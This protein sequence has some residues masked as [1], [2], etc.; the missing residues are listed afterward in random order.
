[1]KLKIITIVCFQLGI[2][3]F[4]GIKIFKQETSV[5]GETTYT[6]IHKKDVIFNSDSKLQFFYEPIAKTTEEDTPPLSDLKVYY[7]I[8]S[9]HLH[10]R[11]DYPINKLPNSYRIMT[12]GDSFTFGLFANTAENY[13]EKLER[14][15]SETCSNNQKFE[16]INLGVSGYDIQYSVERFLLR[17]QKYEPDMI[18]FLLKEDD[19]MDIVEIT[20]PI[21]SLYYEEMGPEKMDQL[22]EVGKC[23]HLDKAYHDFKENYDN[24]N[25]RNYQKKQLER[26]ILNSNSKIVIPVWAE[27]H[28]E[29][30]QVIKNLSEKYPE[31]VEYFELP[32]F[33]KENPKTKQPDWHP[34]PLG[35][36]LMAQTIYKYL[37][38]ESLI[39]CN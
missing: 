23:P 31:R 36:D 6:P 8:N 22:A 37:T 21:V 16:V 13:P 34:T 24:D 19:F 5:L 9:D 28:N 33:Y 4:L 14:L 10:E 30:K 15:L 12:L 32:N 2:V 27:M 29:N 11:F 38:K 25:I 17:G 3:V 18:I 26:L 7:T 1:M 35:Y 39:P 20:A